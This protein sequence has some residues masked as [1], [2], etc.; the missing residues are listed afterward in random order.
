[1]EM[2]RATVGMVKFDCFYWWWWNDKKIV[3]NVGVTVL[4]MVLMLMGSI[5]WLLSV[6]ICYLGNSNN[7]K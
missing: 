5:L 3:R 6:I 1:M 2:P 4:L 7:I